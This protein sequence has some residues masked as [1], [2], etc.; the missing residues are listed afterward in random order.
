MG[1]H[2]GWWKKRKGQALVM[3]ALAMPV[4]IGMAGVGLTVGTVY[5][6]QSK[7]QNAAD[8]A[9]L[10]GAKALWIG[11]P[12][13]PADQASL[14]T[15]ND[16]EATNVKLSVSPTHP[17]TVL[18]S[19][20]VSAPG[21]FASLFGHP[22]FSVNVQAAAQYSPGGPFNYAVFQGDPHAGDAP[23]LLN[24]NSDVVST[25]GDPIANVHSN[26]NLKLNGHI[27]VD[28][29]CEGNPAVSIGGNSSC[30]GSVINHAN[31]IAMPQWT[32]AETTPSGATTV[33]SPSD[34]TGMTV[35]GNDSV[36]GNYVVYGNL[37]INGGSYVSG[38]FVVINGNIIVNGNAQIT[39][40]LVT[41]GGG[42]FMAGNVTQ[43][44]GGALA[45][46]AFTKSG[47]VADSATSPAANNPP[48]AGSIVLNGNVDVHSILYAPDSYVDLNGNVDVH[49]SVI[50]YRVNLNG[51]VNV[52]YTP[53]QD[54]AVPV[55]QVSLIQ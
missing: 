40:S 36:N 27:S 38:H 22:H 50:G 39:G 26:N 14:V 3:V 43:S 25:N 53:S 11:D 41:F 30:S 17:N 37:V 12:N 15:Q 54:S 51:N 52:T 28:G 9:A 45:L 16:P 35:S 42:I 47:Q 7:L 32:V 44:G 1:W 34:P 31:Q 18:V 48:N 23:L 20:H 24:G 55:Q 49:G 4:L 5:Y 2:K 46:A 10:A 33:G 8:A 6:S 13:A 29:S 19:A 21:T